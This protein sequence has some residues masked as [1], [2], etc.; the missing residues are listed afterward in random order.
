M[1]CEVGDGVLSELCSCGRFNHGTCNDKQRESERDARG[2]KM[3]NAEEG[4]WGR[5]KR[6]RRGR[7]PGE[8][9]QVTLWLLTSA[10]ALLHALGS[11]GAPNLPHR[12]SAS[13]GASQAG[14]EGWWMRRALFPIGSYAGPGA[15]LHMLSMLLRHRLWLLW[16]WTT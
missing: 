1:M 15:K 4:R 9:E 2:I 8:A 6:G 7:M 5:I 3:R 10:L 14:T 13:A 16:K 11:E 12:S